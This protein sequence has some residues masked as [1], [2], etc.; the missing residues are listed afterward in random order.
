MDFSGVDGLT[1]SFFDELLVVIEECTE[2]TAQAH[3]RVTVE[4]PPTTLS[5]KF[6]AVGRGHGLSIEKASNGAWIISRGDND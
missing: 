1:P 4:H 3:F 6:L 2:A 5:S